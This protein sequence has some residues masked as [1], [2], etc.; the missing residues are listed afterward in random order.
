M[1]GDYESFTIKRYAPSED[2]TK[3][4]ATHRTLHTIQK[5]RALVQTPGPLI[6]VVAD[7]SVASAEPSAEPCSALRVG[8]LLHRKWKTNRTWFVM[9]CPSGPLYNPRHRRLCIPVPNKH[10][11]R[12]PL[13][14]PRL[15][16]HGRPFSISGAGSWRLQIHFCKGGRRGGVRRCRPDCTRFGGQGGRGA[17]YV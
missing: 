8:R 1:S 2:M 3:L 13:P 15:S 9:P 16:A 6:E 11:I 7:T 5:I 17:W 12:C 14:P 10:T 4:Y